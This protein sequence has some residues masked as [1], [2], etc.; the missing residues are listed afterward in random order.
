MVDLYPI[1]DGYL[2][3]ISVIIRPKKSTII[4]SNNEPDFTLVNYWKSGKILD[5][6]N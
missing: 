3:L 5:P 2:D 1:G 6:G 4:R